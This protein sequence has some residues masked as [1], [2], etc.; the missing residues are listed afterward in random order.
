M[1]SIDARGLACP[2]PV[3]KAKQALKKYSDFEILLNSDVAKE[4]VCRFLEAQ[5]LEVSVEE[6]SDGFKVKVHKE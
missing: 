4:N 6:C 3:I 2:A 5:K 1:E